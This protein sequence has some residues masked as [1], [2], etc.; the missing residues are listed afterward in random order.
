MKKVDKEMLKN[1]NRQII[2]NYI[3]KYKEIS[4]TDLS[5]YTKL[6]P[7]T[8]SAITSEL[9]EKKLITEIRIGE[10]SGGRRPVMVG[11][12]PSAGYVI[13]LILNQKE[14]TCAIVDL[15]CNMVEKERISCNFDNRE[16]VKNVL[17]KSLDSITQKYAHYKDKICGIGVSVPGVVDHNNG[18]VLYSSKL[19]LKNYDIAS[20]IESHTGIKS[21]L[22]KDS[23]ALI[24]GEYNF[25]IASSYKNIVYIN[26][27][28]GVG[29]SYINSGKLFQPGYGG[30]FELGHITIDS[31]GSLCRCG[32]RGCLGTVVSEVPVL[33]KLEKLIKKGY[34]SD[35]DLTKSISLKDVVEYSNNG[36][37]ASKYVLEEQARLLGTAIASVIN[38]FNPQLVA[39]GGPLSNCMWGFLDVLRDTVRDRALETYSRG[40]EIKYAKLGDDSALIGMANEIFEKEIFKPVELEGNRKIAG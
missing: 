16:T 33:N 28:N 11:V 24:L 3:R 25:G 40:V 29:M 26:V 13:T 14:I 30:G 39:L 15:S 5:Q 8:V 31:N 18:K 2:L 22:F 17:Q 34:E 27:D 36:D 19:H 9:M 7:T 20:T 37:R 12:N 1:L 38:L 4:R 6:S 10:S 32:N 35:I 21:Y 23:D